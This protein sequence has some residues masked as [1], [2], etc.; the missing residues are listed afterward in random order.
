MNRASHPGA[1]PEPADAGAFGRVARVL[2]ETA[3][4]N[5][6]ALEW[7][8]QGAPHG[9]IVR[10]TRQT[11]GRGRQGRA[12]HS[13][14]GGLYASLLLRPP[15]EA[16]AGFAPFSAVAALQ[17]AETIGAGGRC[18]PMLKWPND[19]WIAGRKLAGILLESR[20]LPSPAVIVG[21]GVNLAPPAKGWPPELRKLA[22]S[23]AEWGDRRAVE[24]LLAAWLARLEPAY[25]RF[26][27]EGFAA[28]QAAWSGR[29]LLD[30]REVLV[31][32]GD[33]TFRAV[34]EGIDAQARLRVLLAGGTR[35]ALLAGEVH[36]L[37]EGG[38]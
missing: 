37:G 17:L 27:R 23:L 1:A 33:A 28:F 14:P 31:Q 13:P 32:E 35:R 10:A 36:L 20:T 19:V 4:T 15:R 3:S 24:P 2:D 30:G 6:E 34:V 22:T 11:G 29:S 26:L 5:D 21:I 25:E 18:W 8:L 12:W 16:L 7:A 38:P 9:A